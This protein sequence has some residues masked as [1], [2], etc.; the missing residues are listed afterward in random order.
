MSYLVKKKYSLRNQPFYRLFGIPVA[1]VEFDA[2]SRAL[3]SRKLLSAN[4]EVEQFESLNQL[5]EHI[6]N[7]SYE[8]F[9]V[10]PERQNLAQLAQ[11]RSFHPHTPLI[12][13]S[14]MMSESQLDGIMKLGVTMHINRDLSRPRDL[15]VA[16]EQILYGNNN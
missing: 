12:T 8:V 14:K 4:M 7:K 1:L 9:I 2:E 13:L 10:S 5:L 15:L 6:T 16:I 11:L 3:Y